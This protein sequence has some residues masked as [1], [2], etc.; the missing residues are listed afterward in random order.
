MR[1]LNR[2]G[3][4]GGDL[5]TTQSDDSLAHGLQTYWMSTL[6]PEKRTH[7]NGSIVGHN[8]RRHGGFRPQTFRD[9]RCP[10]LH[11]PARR[12]TRRTRYSTPLPLVGCTPANLVRSVTEKHLVH[13]GLVKPFVGTMR[14]LLC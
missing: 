2:K 1:S 13:N 10:T 11:A 6:T 8:C 4:S 14:K 7:N 12:S 9:T 3:F 5:R